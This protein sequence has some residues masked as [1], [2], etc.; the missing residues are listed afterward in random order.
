M[1]MRAQR[2]IQLEKG[3]FSVASHANNLEMVGPNKERFN[4]K[5]YAE[6]LRANGYTEGLTV[7]LYSCLSGLGQASGGP[8]FAQLL[9]NELGVPVIAATTYMMYGENRAP[10]PFDTPKQYDEGS[11]LTHAYANFMR[12]KK[13][14]PEKDGK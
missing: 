4:A 7:K 5:Q 2:N 10:A 3:V 14:Y 1:Y 13:F 12:M 11:K 6:R 9:A 8:S